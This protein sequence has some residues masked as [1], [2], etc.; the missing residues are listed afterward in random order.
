[1]YK[2]RFSCTINYTKVKQTATKLHKSPD[3]TERDRSRSLLQ[4]RDSDSD[5][6]LKPGL[7]GTPTHTPHPYKTLKRKIK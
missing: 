6:A 3:E 2:Q 1:V 5:S 7:R 4:I